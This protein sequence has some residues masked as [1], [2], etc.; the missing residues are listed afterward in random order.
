L[1]VAGL[2]GRHGRTGPDLGAAGRRLDVF[3]IVNVDDG[4]TD[5][6]RLSK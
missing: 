1:D 5:Q 4:W 3:A 2:D 6:I